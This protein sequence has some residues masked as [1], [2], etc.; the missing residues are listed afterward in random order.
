MSERGRPHP[1]LPRDPQCNREYRSIADES[2]RCCLAALASA[3]S[4]SRPIVPLYLSPVRA[5]AGGLEDGEWKR[6]ER[7]GMIQSKF[8]N[9]HICSR[10]IYCSVSSCWSM[11][12]DE[13][14][15]VALA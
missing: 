14:E 2:R 9:F 10:D 5:R 6:V 3:V 4:R 1:L 15:V 8:S 13:T 7:P 12:E 11:G